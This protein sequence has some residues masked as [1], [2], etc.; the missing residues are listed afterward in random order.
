[1]QWMF[2]AIKRAG[3]TDST[4]LIQAWEG[5]SYNMP[6]GKVTMRACDHQIITPYKAALIVKDNEFFS[7]PY[8]G[9]PVIIPEEEITVPPSQTGN[10]RCK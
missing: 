7:F 9:K 10:A 6:W 4:K 1:M 5:A 2:D 3:S 8:T